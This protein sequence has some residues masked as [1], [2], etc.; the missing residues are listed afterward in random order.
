MHTYKWDGYLPR[1]QKGLSHQSIT[2]I[3]KQDRSKTAKGKGY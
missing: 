2:E 1:P 3:L